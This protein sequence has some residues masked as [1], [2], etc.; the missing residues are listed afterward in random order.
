[1]NERPVITISRMEER[2]CPYVA[3]IEKESFPDPWPDAAFS[4]AL[5]DE[6]YIF[7]VASYEDKVCG[8]CG[9]VMSTPE[10]DITNIAVSKEFRRYGIGEMLLECTLDALAKKGI[11]KLFLEVRESNAAAQGLYAKMGFA[12]IGLRK[13]F[14]RMP[15]ENAILMSRDIE[16]R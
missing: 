13:N 6:N 5:V 10:A 12:N 1:M 14:Y 9:C 7:L 11:S 8:F 16:D 4:E 15:T 2:D 3:A